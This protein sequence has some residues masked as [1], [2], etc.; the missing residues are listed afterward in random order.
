M[1]VINASELTLL[2]TR[3]HRTKLHLSLYVPRVVF[4]AQVN[5][6][7]ATPGDRLIGYDNVSSGSYLNVVSGMTM[8]VGSSLGG[9]DKGRVRVKDAG[10]GSVVVAENWHIDWADDL[11]FTVVQYYEPWAVFPRIVLDATNIPVFYKDQDITY[12]DQNDILDPIPMISPSHDGP[13][14]SASTGKSS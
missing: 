4:A 1:T 10:T 2:R 5:N 14:I 13:S 9:H 3:P 7:D 8:Y 12:T 11:Y 6:A